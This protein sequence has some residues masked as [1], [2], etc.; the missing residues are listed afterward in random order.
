MGN[1]QA[2]RRKQE[3]DE[4]IMLH[5][6]II[7]WQY[8]RIEQ[9]IQLQNAYYQYNF[10]KQVIKTK[11]PDCGR[12]LRRRTSYRPEFDKQYFGC[13]CPELVSAIKV[14][15]YEHKRIKSLLSY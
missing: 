8:P 6:F 10:I 14:M 2:S 11:C 5:T 15:E 13:M 1:T 9:R 3:A 12:P 4:V 7:S